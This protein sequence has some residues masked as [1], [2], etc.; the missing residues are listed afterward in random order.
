MQ[1]R[2]V[3]EAPV[4]GATE[5]LTVHIKIFENYI[6]TKY[7]DNLSALIESF[8]ESL[9]ILKNDSYSHGAADLP[10]KEHIHCYALY[11][12]VLTAHLG[13]QDPSKLIWI[14]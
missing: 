8:Y 11:L 1:Q 14:R 2:P 9:D 3:E 4:D 7:E 10:T 5:P 6:K 12:S 13:P